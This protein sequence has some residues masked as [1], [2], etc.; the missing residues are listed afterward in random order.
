MSLLGRLRAGVAL[1]GLAAALG[2]W[3]VT[4]FEQGRVWH[5]P[6]GWTSEAVDHQQF[7]QRV[8]SDP[9]LPRTGPVGYRDEVFAARPDASTAAAFFRGQC[10]YVIAPR[11]LVPPE[12][13]AVTIVLSLA[14][15]STDRFVA[16]VV[17]SEGR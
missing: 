15:N 12:R 9:R 1:A 3:G 5:P 14:P 6:S 16:T 8:A 11:V 17:R 13:A 7:W 4:V 2:W 10:Q